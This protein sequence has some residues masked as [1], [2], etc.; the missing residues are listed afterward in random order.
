MAPLY[1]PPLQYPFH[2]T[3]AAPLPTTFWT[4]GEWR[5]GTS[6]NLA[7]PRTVPGQ[8]EGTQ[9]RVR[10]APMYSAFLWRER[11]EVG[12]WLEGLGAD[13]AGLE[14]ACHGMGETN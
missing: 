8:Y 9:E 14:V 11:P 1:T 10:A 6:G 3:C 7:V 13:S 12:P 2:L 4:D 5:Q